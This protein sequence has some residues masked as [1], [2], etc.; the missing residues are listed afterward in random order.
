M[1][2]KFPPVINPSIS[3]GSKLTEMKSSRI[4]SENPIVVC[5]ITSISQF[6]LGVKVGDRQIRAIVDTAAEVTLISD[7]VYQS[8]AHKPPIVRNVQLM[9]AGREMSM[10]GFIVGPVRL[11]IGNRWYEENVYV[12]PIEQDMLLGFDILRNRGQAVLDM[13]RGILLFDGMEI[14]L[15]LGK[16]EGSPLVAR[17]TVTKKRVIPPNLWPR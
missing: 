1:A 7:K 3:E 13:G 11:K 14:T 5:Q 9:A 17:V 8:L 4:L 10:Q 16:P 12:A 2:A 6:S 15:D